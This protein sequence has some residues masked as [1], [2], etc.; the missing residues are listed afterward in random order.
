MKRNFSRHLDIIAE[1]TSILLLSSRILDQTFYFGN[2]HFLSE[3]LDKFVFHK[4]LKDFFHLFPSMT[5]ENTLLVDD[6][7]HKDMFDP[8]CTPIFFKTFYKS[9]IDYNYLL[10]IVFPYLE[11]L[12]SSKMRVYTFV[13]LNP[14]VASQTW[15]LV[16]L[17]MKN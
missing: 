9:H 3:K 6:M 11:S 17:C 8:P 13:E 2:D 5:F 7:F 15:L 1:K 12:H 10:N 4:N 16:T 14:L